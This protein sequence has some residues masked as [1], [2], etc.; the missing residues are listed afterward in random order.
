M[1]GCLSPYSE[2][3]LRSPFWPKVRRVRLEGGRVRRLVAQY[4]KGGVESE[5]GVQG[6]GT[7]ERRGPRFRPRGAQP[8]KRLLSRACRTPAHSN[9]QGRNGK[10]EGRSRQIGPNM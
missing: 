10:S 3:R 8:G 6:E 1:L 7:D 4:S 5:Y 2:N 9:T